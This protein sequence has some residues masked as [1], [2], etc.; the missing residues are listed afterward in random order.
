[1]FNS[2]NEKCVSVCQTCDLPPAQ[3]EKEAGR[4][5]VPWNPSNW[6]HN[7]AEF[8]LLS[9]VHHLKAKISLFWQNH[10]RREERAGYRVR[11]HDNNLILNC[12]LFMKPK[13][14]QS[15][16]R[17]RVWYDQRVWGGFTL[18]RETSNQMNTT[19]SVIMMSNTFLFSLVGAKYLLKIR[20]CDPDPREVCFCGANVFI[21]RQMRNLVEPHGHEWMNEWMNVENQ[22]HSLNFFSVNPWIIWSMKAQQDVIESAV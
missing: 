1:M 13:L 11:V 16:W 2:C 4:V 5:F 18:H 19:T 12:L 7:D 9:T 6:K 22:P 14:I 17:W 8:W 3:E 15:C 20:K 10:S 21:N